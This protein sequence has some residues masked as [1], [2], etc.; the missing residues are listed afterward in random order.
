MNSNLSIIIGILIPFFGT[1]LGAGIVFF[2]KNEIN[3]KIQKILLGFSAGVMIAAAIWSLIIPALNNYENNLLGAFICSL[4][5][6][7]GVA[8]LMLSNRFLNISKVKDNML[9]LAITL[10]NIIS[11][12]VD[13]IKTF[14]I[15]SH[16]CVI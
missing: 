2:F 12:P 11:V 3:Q 7:S 9:A 4:G 14:T 8:F 1:T 10:H 6:I 15:Q 5:I 13:V 16:W